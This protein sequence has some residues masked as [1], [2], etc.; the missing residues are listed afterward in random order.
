MLERCFEAL[1][2]QVGLTFS[3]KFS[4]ISGF[5][6]VLAGL[7]QS[8]SS[9][10]QTQGFPSEE[11]IQRGCW[12]RGWAVVGEVDSSPS[13]CLASE[14]WPLPRVVTLAQNPQVK[15]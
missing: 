6:S 2:N 9:F 1:L 11:E 7:V 5:Q 13:W 10:I 8:D 12:E 3:Q 14:F 4:K 15:T